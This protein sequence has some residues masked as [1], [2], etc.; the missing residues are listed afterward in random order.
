MTGHPVVL[1]KD[2]KALRLGGLAESIVEA[3]EVSTRGLSVG[4]Q[5]C[6]RELDR[7]RSAQRVQEQCACRRLANL[8]AGLH[9]EPVRG[10]S[11]H[12]LSRL[13]L[14]STRQDVIASQPCEGGIALDG[15][16]PPDDDRAVF[17]GN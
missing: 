7:V 8:M 17:F 3:N 6:C 10:Q 5:E 15:G 12:G 9:L 4:P 2:P 14:V 1:W 16:H 11:R 13:V